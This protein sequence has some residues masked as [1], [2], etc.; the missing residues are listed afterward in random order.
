MR[1]P[2]HLRVCT[3]GLYL[4]LFLFL[5]SECM[6]ALGCAGGRAAGGGAG[7]GT[8]RRGDPARTEGRQRAQ[9]NGRQRGSPSEALL[10][11]RVT[12]R[13]GRGARRPR[14][15]PAAP[16]KVV[17]TFPKEGPSDGRDFP[18]H[19]AR[20]LGRAGGSGAPGLG[21]GWGHG[22]LFRT[23]TH[24]PHAEQAGGGART[25]F[26]NILSPTLTPGPGLPLAEGLHLALCCLS[27][28]LTPRWVLQTGV[29]KTS[30]GPG[31]WIASELRAGGSSVGGN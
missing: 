31:P 21:W 8:G 16:G 25:T 24:T 26:L 23:H 30:L 13:E 19:R 1:T 28:W 7:L 11:R 27:C 22:G 18:T 17:L 2:P 10:G 6:V 20:A 29:A 3:L 14:A 15:L 12:T 5:K 9:V 4:P